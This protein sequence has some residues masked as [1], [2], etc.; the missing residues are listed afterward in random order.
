MPTESTFFFAGL[1][2]I[3]AGLGY[4][5]ARFGDLDDEEEARDA[6]R[7]N[8]LKGFRYLLNEEPD[9][10][11]EAFTTSVEI[12]D[13]VID[14]QV[15]LGA[16][17]RRRGELERAIRLHQNLLERAGLNAE[18]RE[19]AT[20]ALAEDYLAAGLFDRA[21]EL[22]LRLRDS[23]FHRAPALERLLR[24]CE[25]TQEW[26]RAIDLCGDLRR[27][28]AGSVQ[29][30][31][32]AHY[33]CELAERGRTA[34]DP[35]DAR[36]SLAQARDLVPGLPRAALIAGDLLADGGDRAGA[37]G[38]WWALLGEEPA[39]VSEVLPR[40]VGAGG[41]AGA[42]PG[43]VARITDKDPAALRA[44][45][46]AL[47]ATPGVDLAAY[48]PLLARYVASEPV[49]APLVD[50]DA[51]M[52]ADGALGAAVMERVRVSLMA[53]A[54]TMPRYRCGNCGYHSASLQ[55]QC[56]GCRRW[57]TVRATGRILPPPV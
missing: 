28:D 16:L 46:A 54:R 6:A 12:S 7:T 25:V 36:A 21:E 13:E 56:P 1:L 41:L 49:L 48:A 26:D 33:Y 38:A 19:R 17:F 39:L 27:V 45:V 32:L 44:F 42:G 43:V 30:L 23:Q 2:F 11:V 18:Q 10:A 29:P 50:L 14:T 51:L 15:A 24:I 47:V 35:A 34:G 55:W 52:T 20:F 9:R 3:A 37:I 4:V 22:F 31:Q 57:D 5:F 53:A 8:F 40:I